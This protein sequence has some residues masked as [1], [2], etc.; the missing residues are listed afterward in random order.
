[1][2]HSFPTRRSSGRPKPFEV[3]ALGTGAE[4]MT[5]LMVAGDDYQANDFADT[6]LHLV[7][8][9]LVMNPVP[10]LFKPAMEAAFNYDTFRGMDIDSPS[11]IDRKST[12]LN[13]SH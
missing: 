5:E 11:Q 1:M 10:Q 13:P 12:R 4:R 6:L 7:T 8:S 3:G 2:P 9:T